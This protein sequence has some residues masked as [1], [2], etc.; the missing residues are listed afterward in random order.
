MLK[1]FE[2]SL[3]SGWYGASLLCFRVVYLTIPVVKVGGF[4]VLVIV[5]VSDLAASVFVLLSAKIGWAVPFYNALTG[6]RV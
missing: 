2:K 3:V 4:R 5:A 1:F 6:A